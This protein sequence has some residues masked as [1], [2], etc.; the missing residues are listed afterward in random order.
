MK[1][2]R[3][4]NLLENNIYRSLFLF[5]SIVYLPT[6]KDIKDYMLFYRQNFPTESV[7]PKQHLLQFHVIPWFRDWGA[8]LG[9]M[10][11]QGGESV[12][13]QLNNISRDLRG[14]NNDLK[15]N[16][17]CVKNQWILSSP[18]NYNKFS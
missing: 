14:Y 5:F 15:L 6:D 16:V 18:S 12:H 13:C 4:N 10:G 1:L 2:K 11:E 8:S 17:Q 9:M 7:T 3:K